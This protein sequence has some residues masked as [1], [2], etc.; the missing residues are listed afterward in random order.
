MAPLTG[1]PCATLVALAAQGT[2]VLLLDRATGAPLCTPTRDPA[3]IA[4]AWEDHRPRHP[5]PALVAPPGDTAGPPPPGVEPWQPPAGWRPG[6]PAHPPADEWPDPPDPETPGPPARVLRMASRPHPPLDPVERAAARMRAQSFAARA[7]A[8]HARLAARRNGDATPLATRFERLNHALGG[9]FW[10]GLYLIVGSTG[11]GKSQLA[12]QLALDAARA[13][14]PVQYVALELDETHLYARAAGYLR[15]DAGKWSEFFHGHKPVPDDVPAALAA[16]PFHWDVAPPHG[17]DTAEIAHCAAALRR[18]YPAAAHVLV[19]V[20]FLQLVAGPGRDLRERIGT[21][22]YQAKAAARDHDAVVLLISSTARENYAATEFTPH[23]LAKGKAGEKRFEDAT[24]PW[25]GP[26]HALVG[27]GKESGETEYSA[28]AVF[29][30]VKEGWTTAAPPHGG[31]RVH[32]ALAKHRAGV[33]GWLDLRFDG[34][35]FTEPPAPE[36][37]AT[38]GWEALGQL[39]EGEA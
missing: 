17:W 20:D 28:D 32:L 6:V 37:P 15:R 19:V 13:G 30:L 24:A 34:A 9:G 36:P 29:V 14:T 33:P 11:S 26:A 12:L 10:P 1:S 16:L 3:A 4:Q 39:P 18:L 31:T 8:L 22:A 38:T 23:Q 5:R 25:D 21:A 7:D 35:V 27:L 2:Y